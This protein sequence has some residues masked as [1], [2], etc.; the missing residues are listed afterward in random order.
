MDSF[1]EQRSQGVDKGTV[2]RLTKF[3]ELNVR[4][5]SNSLFLLS[6]GTDGLR[7]QDPTRH[8]P[9]PICW[10]T[11]YTRYRWCTTSSTYQRE[12]VSGDQYS[13]DQTGTE[14]WAMQDVDGLIGHDRGP[15]LRRV[16]WY[17]PCG[18][19]KGN[20]ESHNA[21]VHLSDILPAVNR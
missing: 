6:C 17:H 16:L 11:G 5:P 21:Y 14:F 7:N 18:R 4:F 1:A 2:T 13:F 19:F 8:F 15:R 12:H 3:H 20:Q 9:V 10:P